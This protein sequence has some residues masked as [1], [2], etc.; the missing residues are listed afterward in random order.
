VSVADRAQAPPPESGI[1]KI[2]KRRGRWEAIPVSLIE[3]RRLSL[4]TLGLTVWLMS[5][6][7]NWEIRAGALPR[8]LKSESGAKPLGREK[9]R[10]LLREMQ[11]TGYLVRTRL[12]GPNGRWIWRSVLSAVPAT[13]DGLATDGSAVDGR[14]VGGEPVDIV[15]TQ[16]SS[17]KSIT[18]G[19]Q[20]RAEPKSEEK[21]SFH[22][23]IK[24][25]SI[26]APVLA[27]DIARRV[28]GSLRSRF[29]DQ[30]Q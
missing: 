14:T 2:D 18:N 26:E 8:L 11:S 19:L 9:F 16:S 23:G 21:T 29:K 27:I 1:I 10:R 30:S 24:S 3:D 28:V 13:M 17:D 22:N 7:D 6:P 25:R 4:D 20:Y 12:R 5:K 15:Q